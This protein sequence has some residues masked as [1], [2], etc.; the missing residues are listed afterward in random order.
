MPNVT[1]TLTSQQA[2][3]LRHHL[4][5]AFNHWSGEARNAKDATDEKICERIASNAINLFSLCLAADNNIHL[6][7][8]YS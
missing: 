5:V 4:C 2:S 8:I 1:L 3:E 7:E 6:S